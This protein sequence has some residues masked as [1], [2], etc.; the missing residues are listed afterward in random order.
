MIGIDIEMGVSERTSLT[1]SFSNGGDGVACVAGSSILLLESSKRRWAVLL[2]VAGVVKQQPIW[3]CSS[4]C[5]C[6]G[7]AFERDKT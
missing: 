4:V 7:G 3:V 6:S 1:D 5:V 2:V